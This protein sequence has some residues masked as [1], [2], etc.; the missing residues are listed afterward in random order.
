MGERKGATIVS[1]QRTQAAAKAA[2]VDTTQTSPGMSPGE[3]PSTS[4]EKG[5]EKKMAKQNGQISTNPDVEALISGLKDVSEPEIAGWFQPKE[6]AE[7]VGN[8]LKVIQIDTDD[9][10]RD[11][12]LVKLKMPC[13]SATRAGSE[14]VIT[15]EAGQVLGVGMR[16]GL[17]ELLCYV[18]KKGLVYAKATGKMKLKGGK[19]KWNWVIRADEKSKSAPVVPT[20][21]VSGADSHADTGGF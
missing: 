10:Q 14:E 8:A 19:S 21:R 6:G 15:L 2:A 3:T 12:L 1:K 17:Q 16:W 9:G 5:T 18:E 7:F 4:S 13:A 20:A 11:V